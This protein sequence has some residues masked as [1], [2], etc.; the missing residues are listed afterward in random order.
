MKE[1]KKVLLI[2]GAGMSSGIISKNAKK[3]AKKENIKIDFEARSNSEVSPYLPSIDL[4]MIGPHY[5]LELEKFKKMTEPYNVPVITIPR[6]TYA[7]MDGEAIVK[8]ALEN[9]NK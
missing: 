7:M 6:K 8:T 1:R 2:C 4:L 3:Y 5:A 9:F